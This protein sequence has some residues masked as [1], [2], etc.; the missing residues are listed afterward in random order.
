MTSEETFDAAKRRH[1]SGDWLEAEALYHRV[2]E[3]DPRHAAALQLLGVLAFQLGRLDE[4]VQRLSQAIAV[5]PL[6]A[7]C[8]ANLGLVL[9]AR[10]QFAEAVS[11]YQRALVL[12]PA[13]PEAQYNLASVLC[14][15]GRLDEAAV[16]YRR[17]IADRPGYAEAYNNLSDVLRQKGEPHQAVDYSRQALALRPN[18]AEAHN[19]LGNALHDLGR[20]EEALAAFRQALTLRPAFPE[21]QNNLG[22]VLFS[23]GQRT[24]AIACF[25]QAIAVRPDFAEALYNLGIAL[26]ADGQPAEAITACR[27]AVALLPGFVEAWNN[28]GVLLQE[29]GQLPE[30]LAVLARVLEIRPK[31]PEAHCNMGNALK[32]AGRWKEAI[33]SYGRAIAQRPEYPEAYA[34]LGIALRLVGQ[35]DEA[36]RALR[37][38]L[39]LRPDLAEAY[40]NL[41]NVLKDRGEIEEAINCYQQ[42]MTLQPSNPVAGSNRLYALLF[43]PGYDTPTILHE[44]LLWA[45]R[46]AHWLAQQVRP[47]ENDQSPDRRLRIAYFSAE[48]RDHV[49]GYNTWPLFREHD[50]GS[51]ELFCYSDVAHPDS[52][53][54]QFRSRADGWR[55]V[56]GWSDER[57]TQL[58]RQERIDVLIDTTLHMSNNR[59]LVFARKPA[60]VQVTF[61]GYPGTTGLEVMDYRLTDPYLDP[62]GQTDTN[63]VERSVRLPYSFWCYD[64]LVGGPPISPLPAVANGFVTFGCLNNFC[65]VNAETFHL[66]AQV[67][68]AVPS[69]RLLLLSRQGSHRQAT[70]NQLVQR[71]IDASRLQFVDPQPREQYLRV[72]HRIDVGLDTLPYNGHSTSL[73]SLWMG[74]P[75]VTLIGQTVVG[76]AGFSQLS[77]LGLVELVAE[78]K[79]QFIEIAK[80]LAFDL[81]RLA[82][83][84]RGLRQ[85]MEQSP[86]MKAVPFT[87]AVEEAYRQMWRKWCQG[88]DRLQKY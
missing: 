7:E 68:N 57:L 71:G 74:V 59:L 56:C 72:Y 37:T 70:T 65:K 61:L 87:R 85:Q 1:K 14:N 69:S 88:A 86:L 23:Q 84:R 78:S 55:E 6:G 33:D 64:P 10:G 17:A 44:H 19:N 29:T 5:D 39:I 34:N 48:F 42:A 20:T 36:L 26:R 13:F 22:L 38:A 77:N 45:E 67:L 82:E 35:S 46:H 66:W 58:V 52:I 83:L 4:G 3:S 11:A 8:H 31:Y 27:R 40:N 25:Q 63:Y 81:P 9:A 32:Q 75:V 15:Q 80:Q 60:P 41:G 12:R 50:H 28:L 49:I 79:D 2:I 53:T 47:Y 43:H 51:F 54:E 24:E 21:A 76:R 16:A 73:D 30:A 18:F 62:P